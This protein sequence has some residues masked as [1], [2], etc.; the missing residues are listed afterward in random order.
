MLQ[1]DGR[2]KP[3]LRAYRAVRA[4]A[5]LLGAVAAGIALF[6]AMFAI[7]VGHGPTWGVLLV[8]GSNSWFLFSSLI[9]LGGDEERRSQGRR[10][11][12]DNDPSPDDDADTPAR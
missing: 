12:P 4:R 10:P 7:N 2:G 9:G 11:A 3:H 6:V 8:A 5:G 1:K